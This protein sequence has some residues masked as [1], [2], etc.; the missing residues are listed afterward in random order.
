M[1]IYEEIHGTV[2][3]KGKLD[4]FIPKTTVSIKWKHWQAVLDIKTCEPCRNRH[5]KIYPMNEEV[6]PSLEM[7]D[8][9][10]CMVL[11]MRVAEAGICSYEGEN[12]AD[13]W[14]WNKGV[15]PDYYIVIN[16]LFAL[17]W[18]P[19]KAPA[20][21]A[22]DQ[23]LT[24]GIYRNDDGHLPDAPGRIWFEADLNY[25]RGKRNGHRVLWSNDGLMFVTYNHYES[26]IE[27]IG[28]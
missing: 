8:F 7:H 20:K 15:L 16:D 19:G 9:C 27:V 17:G 22:P 24:R 21:Y 10:R 14:L 25:Y 5:G 6:N 26:F 2:I 28:G 1:A 18:R 3:G 23:M 12:G 11:P 4:I 13:W